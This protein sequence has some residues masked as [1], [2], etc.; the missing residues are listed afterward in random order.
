MPDSSLCL[1]ILIL[2]LSVG[3][4]IVNGFNDA[5]NAIAPA[6]GTR[7]VSPRNA[8]IIAVIANMAGAATGTLVAETIGKGIL[9]PEA[10]TYLT[11]IA[12]LASIV[13]CYLPWSADKLAP[14]VY[15]RP[16]CGWDGSGR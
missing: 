11:I 5:A 2:I 3:F 6:I 9:V 4:G 8:L 14:R 16:G 13:I 15:C 10:I 7:A 1:L 12:A